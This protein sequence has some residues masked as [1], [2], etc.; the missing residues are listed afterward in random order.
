MEQR[1]K[2]I[3]LVS[4]IDGT[5][6][7]KFG[8]IPQ[9]NIDAIKRFQAQGG[10]FTVAT[11]R[12]LE[13][14]QQFVQLFDI[15]APLILVNGSCIYDLEKQEFTYNEYLPQT[16]ADY[17]RHFMKH[18]KLANIRIMGG[19]EK[20][21]S[22]YTRADIDTNSPDFMK[23]YIDFT[24]IE[25]L[26]SMEWRKALLITTKEDAS[27]FRAYADSL[28]ISDVD[29]VASSE[30]YYEMVP[31]GISKGNGIKKIAKQLGIDM[32][33]VVAVGD[34]NNDLDMLRVV[35]LGI[36]PENAIDEAKAIAKLVVCHAK[37]G[38][39]GDVVEYLEDYFAGK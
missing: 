12:H 13:L 14:A 16:A 31:K 35:G 15:R 36:A 20:M 8:V 34:Y 21:Y 29:F 11:G 23:Y 33:N 2:D 18:S 6:S 19:D 32:K 30:L 39:L 28:E 10:H 27:E 4:D 24:S 25:K 26:Q 1:F 9:R 37:D 22:V 5:I 17:L 3:L 38:V 7:P